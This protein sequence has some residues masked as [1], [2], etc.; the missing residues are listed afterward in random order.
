M[1]IVSRKYMSSKLSRNSEA[2]ASEF[3]ENLEEMVLRC[4]NW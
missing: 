2:K 1:F 3:I 4:W